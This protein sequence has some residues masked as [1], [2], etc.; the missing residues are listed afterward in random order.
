MSVI[1]KIVQYALN[2]D[3][4]D[5][6]L[7]EESPIAIRVN[8]DIKLIDKI[9]HKKDMDLLL[10]EILDN[11]KLDQFNQTGDLDTSIGLEGLSRI[12]INA[13]VANE[14]RCLTLRILPDNL[15][16]WQD[17]GLPKPFIDLTHKHRGLVLCTGPTGSG[18]S[19]TL[20]AFINCILETQKRHILTIEDPIEFE[21]NHTQ[22]SI[23]HQREVKR[24]TKSFSS[25]LKAALREDPDIIYIGEMRD[26][27]TI[28]LAITAAETGHLVLGTLHTSSAAKTV[29]RI[30]DVFPADQQEQARLQVST[31]LAGIMSQTLC[32][33]KAGKRSLAYEL[34]IN[35]PAIAN[36]IR[37]RKVSQIYSQL[38]TGSSEGMNTLEQC[39]QE[40][41]DKNKISIEEGLG[42]ASNPKALIQN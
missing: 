32:K 10:G 20:A 29:E 35:T 9:L 6:H 30:V 5:I 41:I 15:P 16:K 42:K 34:L 33:N 3:S 14:K 31:S 17:L 2:L 19:T 12:R 1:R 23:I 24:D 4:S 11:D 8:S 18:K 25:A 38:Q 27:E 22:N 28:Q 37:E 40:L 7:E 36:L 21:F 13:Y 39:L 26:L